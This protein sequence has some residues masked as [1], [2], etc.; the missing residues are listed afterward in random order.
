MVRLALVSILSLIAST[1][2]GPL[3]RRQVDPATQNTGF[4]DG[5]TG[6]PATQEANGQLSCSSTVIGDIPNV[7]QMVSTLITSP[8][9]GQVIPAG[10][11]FN[12]EFNTR[13]LE[14]G[15]VGEFA[16]DPQTL[17]NG[18]VRGHL[19]VMIQ[20]MGDDS[21]PSPTNEQ[22][23]FTT[24]AEAGNQFVVPVPGLQAAQ[25]VRVCVEPRSESFIPVVMPIAQ[26]GAQADCVR[27]SVQAGAA[28]NQRRSLIPR[29]LP[30]TVGSRRQQNTQSRQV[31][32]QLTQ[33]SAGNVFQSLENVDSQGTNR[34]QQTV[35]ATGRTVQ[36]QDLSTS[37]ASQ[38]QTSNQDLVNGVT[39]TSD[40][41]LNDETSNQAE[42]DFFGAG[43]GSNFFDSNFGFN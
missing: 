26:R 5:L 18:I 16:K 10:Q 39:E 20:N 32:T 3:F 42:E 30:G 2:A 9:N 12:V 13:N 22:L 19:A 33:T 6:V 41:L 35:D 17:A 8:Q 34:A 40:V 29:Q 27:I 36:R 7:N 1:Q 38:L 31:Q 37:V 25:V 11:G 21:Q 15:V 14:A 4:C 28:A 23:F 43:F 24:V